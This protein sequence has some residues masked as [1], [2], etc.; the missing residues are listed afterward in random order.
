MRRILAKIS[1]AFKKAKIGFSKPVPKRTPAEKMRQAVRSVEARQ[2]AINRQLNKEVEHA[3]KTGKA[4]PHWPKEVR[5]RI[6]D[7]KGRTDN[8]NS[9]RK[10]L[11]KYGVAPKK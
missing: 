5:N 1:G 7:S 11:R 8:T 3:L 2:L 9:I 10:D 6:R 4:P